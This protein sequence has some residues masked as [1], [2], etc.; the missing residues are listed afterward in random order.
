MPDPLF[1]GFQFNR[2]YFDS[3]IAMTTDPFEWSAF[4]KSGFVTSQRL[5]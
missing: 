4:V 3:P 5:A 2:L 1:L